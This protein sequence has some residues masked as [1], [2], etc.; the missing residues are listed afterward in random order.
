MPPPI[1]L[2]NNILV[3]IDNGKM[4]NAAAE[5][6]NLQRDGHQVLLPP[7]VER[8]F[9]HG[10]GFRAADTVRRQ[11]LL[12]RLGVTTDTMGNQVSIQQLRAWRDEAI[13]GGLSITDADIIAQA[14]A[15]AQVR[16]LRNPVLLTKDAGGTLIRMRQRGVLA[17]DF[18]APPVR[19]QIPSRPTP[20]TPKEPPKPPVG[21]VGGRDI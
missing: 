19:T 18:N 15:S 13:H 16:G 14:R 11:G 9:L 8:E 4:P 1:W 10:Q 5:I 21:S 2:D 20:P 12:T 6:A 3:S 17:L 7:S